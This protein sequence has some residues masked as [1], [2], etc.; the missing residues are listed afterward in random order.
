[1]NSNTPDQMIAEIK[2]RF[3]PATGTT[4]LWYETAELLLDGGTWT[5]WP[6]LPIRL[7]LDSGKVIALAW[8]G[9]DTL[10][11]ATAT[12]LPFAVEDAPIR[13]VRNAIP[14]IN[15]IIG[16]K[17]G[18]VLLGRG[19]MSIEGEEIE[20]W[21]RLLVQVGDCWLEIY[22]TLDENGYDYHISKPAGIFITCID[23]G[24]AT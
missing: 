3:T 21:S 15:G 2:S 6:D 24:A 17:I 23:R 13:W 19:A 8:S 11:T 12:S 20:I 22:N 10:W 14:Q 18:A 5:P 1:M 9:F 4:L 7:H 16:G